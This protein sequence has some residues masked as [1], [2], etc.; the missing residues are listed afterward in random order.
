MFT[1]TDLVVSKEALLFG[2]YMTYALSI[3]C[4]AVMD[5]YEFFAKRQLVT[6]FSAPNYRGMSNRGAVID[7]DEV[8]MFSYKVGNQCV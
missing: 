4:Q 7:V 8:L 5:G 6:V 2:V 3:F 1:L